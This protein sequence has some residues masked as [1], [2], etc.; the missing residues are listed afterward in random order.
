MGDGAVGC[1][2]GRLWEGVRVVVVVVVGGGSEGGRGTVP[3]HMY[4]AAHVAVGRMHHQ[5]CSPV[6]SVCTPF[7]PTH[8]YTPQGSLASTAT[9]FLSRRLAFT[10]VSTVFYCSAIALAKQ[11]VNPS[12]FTQPEASGQGPS[13]TLP[14]WFA[15]QYEAR[16]LGH[17]S[18]CEYTCR[19][20]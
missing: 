18:G 5:Q 11:F 19:S 9:H 20:A 14:S 7:P 1:G 3:P 10:G 17:V 4:A 12:N 15:K 8:T 6:C 13:K 2:G 16:R